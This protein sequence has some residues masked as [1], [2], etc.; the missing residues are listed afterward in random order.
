MASYLGF[1]CLPH[2]SAGTV[3]RS[4]TPSSTMSSTLRNPVYTVRGHRLGPCGSPLVP[5]ELSVPGLQ[6]RYVQG[7]EE[8]VGICGC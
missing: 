2:L 6:P 1:R 7:S 4:M 3:P 8:P 5:R